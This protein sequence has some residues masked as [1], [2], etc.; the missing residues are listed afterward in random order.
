MAT[1]VRSTAK[2]RLSCKYV[3]PRRSAELPEES[4]MKRVSNL[5]FSAAIVATLSFAGISRAD[6]VTMN[7]G[8]ELEKTLA[9]YDQGFDVKYLNDYQN[10]KVTPD[11]HD[12]NIPRTESGVQNIQAA[13]EANKPLATRL[14]SKGIDLKDVVNAQQ[15]ADGSITFWLR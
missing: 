3:A 4:A 11:A 14:K 6:D 8:P 15:A 12:A 2:Q 7:W 1:Y 13:I 10:Q 5:A 9:T